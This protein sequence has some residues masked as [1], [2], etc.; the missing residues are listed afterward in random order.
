MVRSLPKVNL[1]HR[2]ILK[3]CSADVYLWMITA[4]LVNAIVFFVIRFIYFSL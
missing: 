3:M 4:K 1:N 2:S